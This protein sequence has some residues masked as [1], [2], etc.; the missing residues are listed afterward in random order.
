M[1]ELLAK[2]ENIF[3]SSPFLGLGVSFLAG[4]LVTFS[5]C[6]YPLIPI[7]LGVV[8]AASAPTKFK[9]FLVSLVFVLGISCVYTVLGIISSAFGILLG[10]FFINP[11]TYFILTII[12]IFL[13]FVHSGIIK[14]KIPFFTN[15][16]YEKKGGL[17]SIFA[18][19]MISSFAIIPCNFPVLGAI[20]SLISLKKN[21]IYGGAALFLFSLGSGMLLLVLGT[22]TSLI[23]SLP[24]SG[25]WVNLIKRG[26][27]VIFIIMGIYFLVKFITLIR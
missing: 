6:I 13:G 19:G 21:I 25:A 11:V 26:V 3:V 12:F 14:I 17:F 10:T 8:G 5:P 9:G 2:L 7:T 16:N 22:F 1:I 24:K 15:Y 18:L 27:G 23:K 4:L 20:L